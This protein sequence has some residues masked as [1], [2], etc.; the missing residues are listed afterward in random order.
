MLSD[1]S[2]TLNSQLIKYNENNLTIVWENKRAPDD[3]GDKW[4]S[5]H[6]IPADTS[7]ATF[8]NG[9]MNVTDGIFQIDINIKIGRGLSELLEITDRFHIQFQKGCT[10]TTQNGYL[11]ILNTSRTQGRKEGNYYRCSLSI[12]WKSYTKNEHFH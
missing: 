9:G 3:L 8:G 1:A 12:R 4:L 5:V 7:R 11:A 6:F 2:M 10:F